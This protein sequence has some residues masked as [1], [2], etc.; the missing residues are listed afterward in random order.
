[1]DK[2]G[3]GACARSNVAASFLITASR[4]SL[5]SC[6]NV[7]SG[8]P[9]EGKLYGGGELAGVR[10]AARGGERNRERDRRKL[11]RAS[12]S[13]VS[14]IP[15][16]CLLASQ[17]VSKLRKYYWRLYPALPDPRL[18]HGTLCQPVHL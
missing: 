18:H 5:S 2:T 4:E 14:R 10:C 15:E 16:C 12:S 13:C 6:R 3:C 17:P 11:N 7:S 8:K 1:M 9:W